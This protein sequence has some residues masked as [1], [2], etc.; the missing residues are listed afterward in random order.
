MASSIPEVS[1]F[2][3]ASSRLPLSPALVFRLS[4]PTSERG[5]KGGTQV[6]KLDEPVFLYESMSNSRLA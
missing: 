1:S 5:N 4:N 3:D 2:R 6:L